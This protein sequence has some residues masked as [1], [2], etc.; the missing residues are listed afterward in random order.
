METALIPL[1]VRSNKVLCLTGPLLKA[2]CCVI[3]GV[4]L[5]VCIMCCGSYRVGEEE[6]ICF[7]PRCLYPQFQASYPSYSPLN[8]ATETGIMVP[9]KMRH[10]HKKYKTK[11]EN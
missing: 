5:S 11:T 9:A 4:S 2:R 7:C 3:E 6:G 8:K 1:Y 10:V